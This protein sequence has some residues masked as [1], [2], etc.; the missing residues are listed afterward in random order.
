MVKKQLQSLKD[1]LAGQTNIDFIERNKP[2][3]FQLMFHFLKPCN[4]KK[5]YVLNEALAF[6]NVF[7]H[8]TIYPDAA[9][10]DFLLPRPLQSIC[11]NHV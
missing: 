5:S 6:I 4:S 2:C 7:Q 1:S 8:I 3:P 10:V 11:T 9:R